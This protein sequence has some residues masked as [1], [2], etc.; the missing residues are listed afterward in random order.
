[1]KVRGAEA[2]ERIKRKVPEAGKWRKRDIA[3]L[4]LVLG[5][6]LGGGGILLTLVGPPTLFIGGALLLLLSP[7]LLCTAPLWIPLVIFL[8][9]LLAIAVGFGG[10]ALMASVAVWWMYRYFRGPL[11][12][13]G[14]VLDK[15]QQQLQQSV[16]QA[17]EYVTR[18]GSNAG[19]V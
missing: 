13:G 9:I 3:A 18:M 17:K 12:P 2:A 14:A 15:T 8:G 1:M 11:P 5:T 19:G 16:L 6:L 7:I 4:V 10:M